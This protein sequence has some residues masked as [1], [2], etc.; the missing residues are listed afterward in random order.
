MTFS[1]LSAGG[2]TS[3]VGQSGASIGD[4]VYGTTDGKD[5]WCRELPSP[6]ADLSRAFSRQ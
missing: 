3:R 2:Q 5:Q 1:V 6:A 4:D